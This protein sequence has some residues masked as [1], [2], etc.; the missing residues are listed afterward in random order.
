MDGHER[1][2]LVEENGQRQ[3]R[4]VDWEMVVVE[5]RISPLRRSQKT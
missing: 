2:R 3:E 5:R 1:F 4:G